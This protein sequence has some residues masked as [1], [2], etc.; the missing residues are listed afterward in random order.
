MFSNYFEECYLVASRS[1][2][3]FFCGEYSYSSCDWYMGQKSDVS[4]KEMIG[5]WDY[6]KKINDEKGLFWFFFIERYFKKKRILYFNYIFKIC[7]FCLVPSKYNLCKV[8]IKKSVSSILIPNFLFFAI[9]VFQIFLVVWMV[10][11]KHLWWLR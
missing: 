7:N 8:Y 1:M 3:S 4:L 11:D 6:L 9:A 10:F 2:E 5:Y